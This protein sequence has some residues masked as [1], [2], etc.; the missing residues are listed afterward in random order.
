VKRQNQSV[1]P[2]KTLGLLATRPYNFGSSY[3]TGYY[4][5]ELPNTALGWEYSKTW[6]FGLDFALFGGRVSGTMEYYVQ[7]TED[8]LLS[9]NLPQTS[10]VSS[11]MA[12]IGKTRNKGFEFS[13]NGTILDNYNGWTWEAGLN[14]YTNKNEL[15]SLASGSKRD[16]SNWWF[17]GHPINVIY[18]YQK[19]GIWQTDEEAARKIA[20]PGGNA[21]MIKIKYNGD[22]DA[23]GLPT[24]A[25]STDDRQII[26]GRSRLGKAVSTHAWHIRT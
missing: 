16:E 5:S 21:G 22:Y 18:D 23:N 25:Y 10:G 11:Y 26:K 6:N 1:D 15:I 4:V 7:N 8:L 3:A 19:V 24:R 13:V 20:E 17:V 2:Y 12:N 9:V 14:F